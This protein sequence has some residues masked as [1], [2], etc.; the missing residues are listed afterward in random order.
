MGTNVECLDTT[1]FSIRD[2]QQRFLKKYLKE[3]RH[4]LFVSHE[5]TADFDFKGRKLLLTLHAENKPNVAP[6]PISEAELHAIWDLDAGKFEKVDFPPSKIGIRKAETLKPEKLAHRAC[7]ISSA[8]A[9]GYGAT[10]N[11]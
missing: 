10:S 6:G 11:R 8:F 4:Y 1:P 9:Q 5:N 7:V 2:F 3:F